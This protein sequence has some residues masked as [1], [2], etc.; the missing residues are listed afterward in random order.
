METWFNS[1][2]TNPMIDQNGRYRVFRSDRLVRVGDGVC[3]LV[4]SE[5]KCTSS[6]LSC[7][8]QALLVNSKLDLICLDVFI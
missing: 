1:N 7:T 8:D 2:I 3:A 5:F 4:S 6:T